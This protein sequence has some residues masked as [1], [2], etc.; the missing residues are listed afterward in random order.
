MEEL[1]QDAADESG[2]WRAPLFR[3]SQVQRRAC[4]KSADL[5]PAARQGYGPGGGARGHS[6]TGAGGGGGRAFDFLFFNLSKCPFCLGSRGRA[7][8]RSL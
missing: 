5:A 8:P 6:S 3:G 1:A 4:L 7:L 2:A